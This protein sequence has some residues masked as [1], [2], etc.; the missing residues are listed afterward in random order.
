MCPTSVIDVD[1]ITVTSSSQNKELHV[2]Y[3]TPTSKDPPEGKTTAVI[4]VMRGK[5]KDGYHHHCT[6]KHYE[7]TL[8]RV[9]LDSDSDGDLV[10]V[11]KNKPV[12]LPYS[13]RLVPQ[14][15][16]TLNRIFQTKHKA[17]VS[18]T[19]LTAKGTIQNQMWLSMRRVL[20][21]SMTSFL[22]LKP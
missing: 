14:S 3:C 10:F 4:A 15:W 7:Q 11:R 18:S 21:R 9:L 19:T 6:N 20:S 5:T 16:N 8:V 13:K 1:D 22:I 17:R 2:N 12:L